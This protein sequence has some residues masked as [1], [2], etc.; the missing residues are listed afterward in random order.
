MTAWCLTA[1][2]G[3]PGFQKARIFQTSQGENWAKPSVEANGSAQ[4]TAFLIFSPSTVDVANRPGVRRAAAVF[5]QNRTLPC[6]AARGE[7]RLQ[8]LQ[9]TDPL[10]CALHRRHGPRS[11][12]VLSC[13][14][15]LS[16]TVCTSQEVFM[17]PRSCCTK[18]PQTA[19]G[20]F[21]S[22]LHQWPWHDPHCSHGGGQSKHGRRTSIHPKD[23]PHLLSSFQPHSLHRALPEDPALLSPSVA[24]AALST[25]TH[26]F[27]HRQ[28]RDRP[29]NASGQ[30]NRGATRR[31]DRGWGQEDR[32]HP[33]TDSR[34]G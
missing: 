4:P 1:E 26:R 16:I 9:P 17:T 6:S 20:Q 7:A 19:V 18:S 8:P 11:P 25:P 5:H 21:L 23:E 31:G 29:H 33:A 14:E 12:S 30:R 3:E 34:D 27:G 13:W 10:Q 24:E 15:A 22:H 2:M 28:M 32:Q